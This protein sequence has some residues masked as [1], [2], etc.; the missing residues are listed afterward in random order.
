[1]I[2][3]DIKQDNPFADYW[4]DRLIK[5]VDGLQQDIAD[6]LEHLNAFLESR[7]PASFS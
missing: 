6:K 1:M 2:E 5:E 4:F 3:G 7:L